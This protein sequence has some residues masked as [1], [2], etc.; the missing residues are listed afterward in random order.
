MSSLHH[1]LL[2]CCYLQGNKGGVG[3]RFNLYHSSLCFVNCHFAASMEEVEKRNN[4]RPSHPHNLTPSHISHTGL[5]HHQEQ[6]DLFKSA[7]LQV[8]H[9]GTR[10]SRIT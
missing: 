3:V 9:H 5:S 7:R 2:C 1:C 6:D 10:V 8:H 4:V